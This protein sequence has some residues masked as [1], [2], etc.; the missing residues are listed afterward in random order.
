MSNRNQN[1]SPPQH[2]SR[3]IIIHRVTSWLVS[4]LFSL[5]TAFSVCFVTA[6]LFNYYLAN[7]NRYTFEPAVVF[8]FIWIL[9]FNTIFLSALFIWIAVGRVHISLINAVISWLAS[10]MVG[11]G[12][13]YIILLMASNNLKTDSYKA[14]SN[15]ER[16]ILLGFPFFSIVIYAIVLTAL[17]RRR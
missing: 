6:H 11:I 15:N 12:M 9:E 5:G 7:L 2:E 16:L 10:L 14:F 17:R 3:N 4:I 8:V 1:S 13:G